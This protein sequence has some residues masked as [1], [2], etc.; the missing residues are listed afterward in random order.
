MTY[1]K[2]LLARAAEKAGSRYALAKLTGLDEGDLSKAARGKREVPA[3]WV[4][5]LARVAG[6]DPTEAMEMHD[7]ERS[8]KKRARR[9]LSRSAAAGVAAICAI[10]GSTGDATGHQSNTA[11]NLLANSISCTSCRLRKLFARLRGQVFQD[12]LP[13]GL[14]A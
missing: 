6:I 1:G 2:D 7:L 11:R 9:L 3:S 12:T 4:L 10:F 13:K 8:E 5:K 14:H